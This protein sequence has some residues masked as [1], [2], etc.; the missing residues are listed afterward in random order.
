MDLGSE[1]SALELVE[2][3]EATQKTIPHVVDDKMKNNHGDDCESKN[4]GSCR[5]DNPTQRSAIDQTGDSDALTADNHVKGTAEIVPLMHSPP[6]VAGKSPGGSSP[7]TTKGYG[8][9]KWRRIKRDFVKDSTTSMDSSKILKRGLTGSANPDP[10]KPQQRASPE[11]KQNRASPIGPVNMLNTSVSPGSM[12]AVG[13]A[14]ASATDSENSEDRSSKSSTAA[15]MPKVRYDLPAVL[16]YMHDKNQ[17]KNLGGNIVGNSSHRVHQGKGRAESSK[18]ARGV[19]VKIDKENS[20]SSMESDSRSSNFIFTQHPISVTSNGK[21]SGNPMNYD[22]ENSDEAHEDDHQISEEVQTVYRKE[23]SGDIEELSPEDL[24]AEL[25]WEDK[26][27]KS[28]NHRPSPDQDPL[29]QSIL[30]LQSVQEA[31]ENEVQKLVEIGKEPVRDGSVNI[32][33]V[34]VDSTFAD[35]EIHET[36]SSDQLGSEKITKSASGSLE[37][38]VFTLTHKVK[39]LESKLEEARSVLQ[40]KESKISELKTSVKSSGSW[41]EESRSIAESQQNEC[42]EMEFDLE[43]LFQKKMEAE[44]EFL[45]L[46]WE[47]EKLKVSV[48]NQITV[49]EEQ[50]SLVVEQEQMLNKLGEVESKAVMLKKQAEE[51]EKYHGNILDVEEVLQMRGRVCKVM[52]CFFTQLVLLVLVFLFLILQLSIHSGVV[53]PT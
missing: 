13:A 6:L 47:I 35:E 51:L 43:G 32:N 20:H 17:M 22:G 2:D 15:S 21:Q 41:K 42:R 30:A 46:T 14:F 52:S 44:I 27:E 25:S 18:K 34:H 9:K 12:F 24:A 50:T 39:Y 31:L 5:I 37:T 49:V 23:N 3:N 38:Q 40:V 33:N 29:V 26:E 4:N 48:G 45:V 36:S 11:I 16:G 53:V 7:P 10:S 19:R 28:G 1:C 8:L